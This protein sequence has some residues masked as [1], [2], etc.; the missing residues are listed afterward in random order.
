MKAHVDGGRREPRGTGE[1]RTVA[2]R[3]ERWRGGIEAPWPTPRTLPDRSEDG[4]LPGGR[5]VCHACL[6]VLYQD[7]WIAY[8]ERHGIEPAPWTPSVPVEILRDQLGPDPY[9]FDGPTSVV[10][11][12]VDGDHACPECGVIFEE[13]EVHNATTCPVCETPLRWR[14]GRSSARLMSGEDPDDSP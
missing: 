7:G 2:L 13:D 12:L 10:P 14:R 3:G 11:L 4:R 1:P 6:G 5:E 8:M 9:L